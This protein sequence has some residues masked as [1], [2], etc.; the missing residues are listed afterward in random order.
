MAALADARQVTIRPAYYPPYHSKYNSVER[1]FILLIIKGMMIVC[2]FSNLFRKSEGDE[3]RQYRIHHK[4]RG[5]TM[6]VAYSNQ[7]VSGFMPS[8][9]RIPG[10]RQSRFGIVTVTMEIKRANV[11]TEMSFSLFLQLLADAAFPG[12]GLVGDKTGSPSDCR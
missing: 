5:F 2:I 11:H 12:G 10:I 6:A 9:S 7:W 8:V 1:L 4:I 3:H